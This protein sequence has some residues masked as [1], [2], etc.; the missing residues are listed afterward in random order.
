MKK[1]AH[2]DQTD[3]M[4]YASIIEELERTQ[5]INHLILEGATDYIYQLD[6]VKD[7]CT[8]SPHALEVLP[9]EDATFPNALETCLTFIIPEDRQI[10]LDSFTPFLTGQSKFHHAEYRVMT[11][12]GNIMWMCCNGKGLHDANG[13]PLIIAGSLMDVTE[14]KEAD[15]KLSKMLYYDQ[16]TGVKNR[17]GFDKDLGERLQD[18]HAEGSVVYLD[19]KNFKMINEVFGHDFGNE[20]LKE[21]VQ[22]FRLLLPDSL[23]IYRLSGDEFIAHLPFA[24][25]DTIIKH[26]TPLLIRLKQPK[27]ILEHTLHIAI[28]MGISIYP[29][30]GTTADE[31]LKNADVAM[32]SAPK[33]SKGTVSFYLDSTSKSI[34][35]KY[36]IESELRTSIDNN[37][38]NFRV[39]YQP[40]VDCKT[41][42]W[43]GAEALLRFVSPTLGQI[44]IDEVIEI[45]EYT[46]LIVPVG[47]WIVRNAMLECLKWH[48]KGFQDMIIHVNCSAIQTN[49]IDFIEY[50]RETMSKYSFPEGHLVCELTETLLLNNMENA[51]F[52]CEELGKMGVK[53]ALDDFG[54]GYS[55]LSYLRKLPIDEI[56]IDKSFALDYEKDPYY[57]AVISTIR[58]LADILKMSVCVE[59][60]ETAEIYKELDEMNIDVLQ[61]FYFAKPLEVDDFYD[62]LI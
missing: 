59:G 1:N 26:L 15:E 33:S 30:H 45:L 6:L 57:G 41:Q 20:V 60:V 14:K 22:M 50:L 52:F 11:K 47:K 44:P 25:K 24:D 29:E 32:L 21:L 37:F 42:K 16:M 35:R 40:I 3:T 56:K 61:G 19:V 7:V 28:N 54:T 23:G 58:Q 34:S 39:V 49:D 12:Q 46:T 51:L 31:I 36:Q 48:K 53:I 9:L 62:K 38:N 4:Q 8:F 18:P 27:S 43:I 13:N 17:Y 55:S 2:F 10:F 5:Q